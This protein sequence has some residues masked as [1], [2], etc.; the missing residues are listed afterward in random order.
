M[1]YKNK[2]LQE[3]QNFG[4]FAPNLKM[5]HRFCAIRRIGIG[6]LARWIYQ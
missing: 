1:R 6:K 5:S 4:N 3:S 2:N